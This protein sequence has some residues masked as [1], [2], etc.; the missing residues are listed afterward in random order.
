MDQQK[1]REQ[2]KIAV[3]KAKTE[4]PFV[5]SI[6]NN[7]TRNYVAD[8][9]LA[10]GG[11]AAMINLPDEGE[12]VAKKCAAFYFNF[13]TFSNTLAG[14]V[15]RTMRVL[16][17]T[18]KPWVLDPVGI[19]MG[20]LRTDLLMVIRELPPDIIRGNASEIIALAELWGLDT[21]SA[22][23][24][25]CGVDSVETST[26]ARQAAISLARH[27]KG[28]VAVSGEIDLVTDGKRVFLLNGGSPLFTK[29]SGSGCAL[30]GVIAV[31]AATA[32]NSLIAALSAVLAFNIAGKNAAKTAAGPASFKMNFLDEL[33]NLTG[34]QIAAGDF[35]L[36]E[37]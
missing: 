36:E 31:Y 24:T 16:H 26:N 12:T 23:G 6:T 34:E 4:K 20:G 14:T 21:G 18:G 29:I 33:Y 11:S 17:G 32:E 25:L 5:P 10:V 37:L 30:G 27:I 19:G 8:A 13:G 7:V 15:P 9:Q 2:I 22:S 28:V 3:N 35:S 1:L